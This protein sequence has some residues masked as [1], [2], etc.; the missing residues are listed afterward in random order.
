M[1]SILFYNFKKYLKVSA[2]RTL[3]DHDKMRG[4]ADF[5]FSKKPN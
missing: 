1:I 4:P 3:D 2:V 5:F